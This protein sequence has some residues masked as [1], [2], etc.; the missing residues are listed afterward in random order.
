MAA[1]VEP[2]ILASASK[3]RARM[4]EA[5]G[6]AFTIEPAAIDESR[7]K[8]ASRETGRRRSP[9]PWHLQPGRRAPYHGGIAVRW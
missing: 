2:L 8:A 3:A 6:V 5:A 1:T 7:I 9:V 4:L